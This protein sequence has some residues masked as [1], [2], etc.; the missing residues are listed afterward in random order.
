MARFAVGEAATSGFGVVVRHPLAV[1]GWALALV[2]GLIVPAIVGLFWLGPEFAR[3]IQMAL[4]QKTGATDPGMFEDFM[5]AQS[6]M[7]ALNILYWLWSSF[8]R[9]VLC[10]AVFRAVLMPEASAWA[11]LRISGRELW[12][13]LLF[14]VEQ[15]LAMIVIFIIALL[16][17][18]LIAVVA[19]SGGEQAKT[20]AIIVG[21][22]ATAIAAGVLIW[23]A[24]RLSLAAPMTFADAQFRLFESWTLT[25]GQGW[26]LLGMALLV[27][28]FILLMEVL[29]GAA[30]FGVLVAAGG[31]LEAIRGPGALEAFISRPPITLLTALWPWLLG[32]G[33]LSAVF[34]AVLQAV[35]WAPWAA[36]HKAL[37]AEA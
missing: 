26:R 10:G 3:L 21:C 35:F 28:I 24:L 27:V 5:R 22:S 34:S 19:V 37:T 7:T 1:G 18:V 15:V 25:R 23:V 2:V 9:A 33:A 16:I 20:T 13:T 30:A 11:F 8:V 31:S 14:V 12:M 36:A 4:T 6:S 17:V 32:L 29:V